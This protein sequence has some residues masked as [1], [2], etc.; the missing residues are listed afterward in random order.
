MRSTRCLAGWCVG[1]V[2]HAAFAITGCGGSPTRRGIESE[3]IAPPPPVE[4]AAP[5]EPGRVSRSGDREVRARIGASGGVLELANGARLEIGEGALA[6]ST[7]V[8]FALGATTAALQSREDRRPIGPVLLVEPA[9]VAQPGQR[10][11]LSIPAAQLPSGFSAEDLA[12]AVEQ[13]AEERALGIGGPQT[14]WT[15]V[16]ARHEGG[17][18]IA[19][20]T[21]LPGMRLGFVVAR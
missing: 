2:A 16:T 10:F 20:L 11:I 14:R 1:W 5:A 4:S 21:E 3:Q 6:T 8:T 9:L 13:P 12:L 15:L 18:A 17:R 7:E 19:E